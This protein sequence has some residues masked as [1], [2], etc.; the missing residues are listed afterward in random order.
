MEIKMHLDKYES[1]STEINPVNISIIDLLSSKG[2][3]K[4]VYYLSKHDEL[5]VT[6]IVKKTAMNSN[7]INKHLQF[8][9]EN[10]ILEEKKFGR[11]KI[12]RLITENYKLKLLKK[13][14][15]YWD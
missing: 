12:Y 9:V 6:Q 1:N 2:K 15:T 10:N 5:N 4:I 8:F 3:V 11:V 14:F 13:I 7:Q